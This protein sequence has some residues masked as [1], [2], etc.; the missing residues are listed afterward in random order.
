MFFSIWINVAFLS[1]NVFT[2]VDT[3]LWAVIEPLGV[4]ALIKFF[5]GLKCG[6][7]S[8][9]I[10]QILKQTKFYNQYSMTGDNTQL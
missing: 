6:I 9:I 10:T 8:T 4:F 1:K 5:Q 3:H 7:I 2:D